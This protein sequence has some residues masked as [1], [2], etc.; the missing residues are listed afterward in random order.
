MNDMILT[1]AKYK[2]LVNSVASDSF[3]RLVELLATQS[4]EFYIEGC[5]H[6]QNTVN[7]VIRAPP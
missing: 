2:T 3:H 4:A 1:A 6:K 7:T 5:G